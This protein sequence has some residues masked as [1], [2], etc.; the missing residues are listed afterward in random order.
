M[1]VSL[2]LL[3]LFLAGILMAPERRSA[4]ML[5]GMFQ[6]PLGLLSPAFTPEYWEP[7]RLVGARI[8]IEDI[9]FSFACGGLTW[10]LASRPTGTGRLDLQVD[11]R[12]MLRGFLGFFIPGLIAGAI[13]RTWGLPIM[14]AAFVVS[15]VAGG[16]LA[17]RQRRF[18]RL[19]WIGG[20]SFGLLY[21]GILKLSFLAW[22][23]FPAQWHRSNIWPLDVAGI[24]LQEILWGAGCGV[25]WPL[26]MTFIFRARWATA[27]NGRCPVD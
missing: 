19:S 14:D 1:G 27:P 21:A 2:A 16:Y 10:L 18:L 13:V 5:S 11:L 4:A 9:L 7:V 22:P 23:A 8:G 24:P 17:W 3:V 12:F 20:L 6:A 15:L 25:V 26:F